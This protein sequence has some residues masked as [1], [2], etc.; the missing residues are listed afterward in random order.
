MRR[1]PAHGALLA[2]LDEGGAGPVTLDDSALPGDLFA[3]RAR[4][5]NRT[6]GLESRAARADTRP[7]Q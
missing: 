6:T 7:V 3:T 4:R 1:E 5:T 2:A